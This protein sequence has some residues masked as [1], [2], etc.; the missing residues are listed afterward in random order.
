MRENPPPRTPTREKLTRFFSFVFFSAL[1]LAFPGR[2]R[3]H[4]CTMSSR[5]RVRRLETTSNARTVVSHSCTIPTSSPARRALLLHLQLRRQRRRRSNKRRSS[6]NRSGSRTA[7][8]R[9]TTG[10]RG[11]TRR[12]RRS[13]E[14]ETKQRPKTSGRP[15]SKTCGLERSR[16]RRSKISRKSTKVSSSPSLSYWEREEKSGTN[17]THTHG[18]RFGRGASRLV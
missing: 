13:N 15:I 5:C 7:S 14:E 17:L 2:T 18:F 4:R 11:T 1:L 16:V 10:A 9:T 6:F 3:S 8:S 12:V